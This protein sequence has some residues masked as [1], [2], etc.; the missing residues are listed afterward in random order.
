MKLQALGCPSCQQPFQVAETQAGEVVACP[1]CAQPIEIP[2]NVFAQ[3][4]NLE[5]PQ[6]VH[7][8][9]DCNGQFGV[10][11]D[12]FGQT[13]GC[14]HCEAAVEIGSDGN[15]NPP[16]PQ[17]P[18]SDFEINN[19][20]SKTR[21][22]SSSR[23]KSSKSKYRKKVPKINPIET[24][25]EAEA[26]PVKMRRRTE[27]ENPTEKGLSPAEAAQKADGDNPVV[28]LDL[29]PPKKKRVPKTHLV[30]SSQSEPPAQAFLNKDVS[31]VADTMTNENLGAELGGLATDLKINNVSQL[32]D[33]P[34]VVSESEVK[35]DRVS[36]EHLLPPRFDVLDPV[37]LIF[38]REE[39]EF[40]VV[41]P[42]GD[43]GTKQ[44]DNRVVRVSHAGEQVSLVASSDKE[45]SRRRL[46][47]NVIAIM[48]GIMILAGAFWLLG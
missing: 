44:V 7:T 10:T 31:T 28:S 15:K 6:H 46:I 11:P 32:V 21:W 4:E 41:L 16:V 36:I 14:P 45:K 38:N 37:R 17:A 13:V 5:Q 3:P 2:A 29:A 18:E 8:C 39:S 42:D 1:S 19:K 34:S 27:S 30:V 40:K 25:T 23:V 33:T 20:K 26:G 47:Q 22:K 12:M 48:I 35:D 43:G 24:A 9:S